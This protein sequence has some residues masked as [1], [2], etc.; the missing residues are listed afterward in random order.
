M[1][2]YL[3]F[4]ISCSLYED[5]DVVILSWHIF[6]LPLSVFF[7]YLEQVTTDNDLTDEIQKKIQKRN[8]KLTEEW[9]NALR[10]YL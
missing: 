2:V 4:S 8:M 5:L 7:T 6:I 9:P 1:I 10:T 3:V